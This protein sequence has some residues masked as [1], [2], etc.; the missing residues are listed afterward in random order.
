MK[1]ADIINSL[2]MECEEMWGIKEDAQVSGLGSKMNDAS[3]I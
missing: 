2:D 3:M 1:G